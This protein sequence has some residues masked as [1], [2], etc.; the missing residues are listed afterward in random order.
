MTTSKDKFMELRE[1]EVQETNT[2]RSSSGNTNVAINEKSFLELD[3]ESVR[4][5]GRMIVNKYTDGNN[6]PYAGLLLAKKLIDLGEEIKS[7]I[8]DNAASELRL[9]TGEK[10]VVGTTTVNEQM[11]GVRYDFKPCNDLIW[12]KLSEAIK[13][14][15]AFL[16]TVTAPQIT[17]D[18]DTGETWMVN[19]PVKS[20]K[21]GLVIKY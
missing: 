4:G 14:R 11:L 20:G 15:E 10:R 16:K 6:S 1:Q 18:T 17:G 7:N 21:L 12:N 5:I 8:S 13:E 9:A 2:T 19:P 3:K